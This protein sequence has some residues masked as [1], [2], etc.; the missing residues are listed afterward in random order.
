MLVIIPT[1]AKNANCEAA[2][3]SE[4]R[5]QISHKISQSNLLEALES[6][7]DRC[8]IDKA[9]STFIEKG[10]TVFCLQPVVREYTMLGLGGAIL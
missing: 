8:L 6:L 3:F 9:T 7:T 1:I 5:D 10:S 2:S 4:L